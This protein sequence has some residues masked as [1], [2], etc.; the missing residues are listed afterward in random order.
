M[1]SDQHDLI[2]G[3][4][5]AILFFYVLPRASYGYIQCGFIPS[6]VWRFSY[7]FQLF[8]CRNLAVNRIFLLFLRGR[9][10][11]TLKRHLDTPCAF[12]H[13]HMCVCP[14]MFRYCHMLKHP[15]H[16]PHA[17][18][19]ICMFWEYLHV[20]WGYTPHVGGLGASAHLSGIWCLSVH[21]LDVYYALYLSCSSSCLKSLLLQI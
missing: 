11:F 2:N 5:F 15:M 16:V 1:F 14:H 21:P 18:L 10:V 20:I 3:M 13:P 7:Y 4:Y 9:H 8:R 12:V 19:C 6:V 17:P